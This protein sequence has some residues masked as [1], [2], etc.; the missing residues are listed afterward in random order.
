MF[1]IIFHH[2][3]GSKTSRAYIEFTNKLARLSTLMGGSFAAE[4][5]IGRVKIVLADVQRDTVERNLMMKV[6]ESMDDTY[7]LNPDVLISSKVKPY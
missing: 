7:Q 2:P 5:G 3:L 4:H 6:K 1:T